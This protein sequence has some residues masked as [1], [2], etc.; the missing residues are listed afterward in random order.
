MTMT[1]DPFVA[2]RGLLFTGDHVLPTVFPGLGLGG[3]TPSN[4]LADYLSSVDALR[5]YGVTD[6]P[7]P[8]TPHR[9]W[10]LVN[11]KAISEAPR[12]QVVSGEQAASPQPGSGQ[13]PN[14]D[15]SQAGGVQ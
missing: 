15:A 9:V 2:H 10:Q 13:L 6:V 7:M 5:P 14:G 3:A 4:P 11:G 1:A 8:C 12:P